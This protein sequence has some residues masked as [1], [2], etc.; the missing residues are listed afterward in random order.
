MV[1]GTYTVSDASCSW[2]VFVIT[3]AVCDPSLMSVSVELE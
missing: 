3:V 2:V 1:I